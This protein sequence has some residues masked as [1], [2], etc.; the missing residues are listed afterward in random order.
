MV[1][2]LFPVDRTGGRHVLPNERLRERYAIENPDID[3]QNIITL[4][5]YRL[6]LAHSAVRGG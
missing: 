2:P 3:E 6:A 1:H 4:E 5:Q